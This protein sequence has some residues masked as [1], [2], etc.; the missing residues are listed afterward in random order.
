MFPSLF[1]GPSLIRTRNVYPAEDI[2]KPFE[3]NVGSDHT[4]T[5]EICREKR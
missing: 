3:D 2:M 4:V 1:H 5:D